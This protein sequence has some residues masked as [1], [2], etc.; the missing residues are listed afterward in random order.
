MN[1]IA[2]IGTELDS[3]IIGRIG[4]NIPS[5]LLSRIDDLNNYVFYMTFKNK[6]FDDYISIFVHKS[7]D[8]RI[9]NNI[10]PDIAVKIFSHEFSSESLNT[11]YTSLDLNKNC[12]VGYE[13]ANDF[14]LLTFSNTPRL[15]QEDSEFINDLKKKGFDFFAQID[16]SYYSE[17][18]I[19][20]NY[21]FGFGALYL[22]QK[23]ETSEVIA[24]FWQF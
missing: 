3:N 7:F 14:D 15:I 8:I 17:N 16:E 12:V 19:K 23:K 20:G 22:F 5:V 18:T 24:G 10:Y 11:E 13:S 6:D 9:E 4:G 21:I 1:K 2:K